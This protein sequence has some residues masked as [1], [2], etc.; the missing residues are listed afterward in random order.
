MQPLLSAVSDIDSL[1]PLRDI[2]G[3]FD[4]NAKKSL[5]QNFL[6]DLNITSKIVRHAGDLSGKTVFEI[7]P[8]PGGLTREILKSD[9]QKVIAVEFDPRAVAALQSLKDISNGRLSIQQ[10]DAMNVDLSSLSE[11]PR[12]IIANLP[13]NIASPLLVGWLRQ[14]YES[15]AYDS[16][17]LMF[18]K[19]V[20]QRICAY[21]GDKAYGR[22]A[23]ISQAVCK[24]QKIFD[25]PASAFVPPPKV[26]SSI[27]HFVPKT[28]SADAPRFENIEE[29]TRLAFGQ[30]RK[31]IRSSLKPYRDIID[32]LGIDPDL[33]A[34]DLDIEAY[35]NIAKK[36]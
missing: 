11:A 31:M 2:I 20:A 34:D 35:L 33:R 28:L 18:Q 12:C 19:E 9:A 29:V 27:V 13:Y 15:K 17:T 22:L 23:V 14:I 24:A 8:G 32:G 30:R 6:L 4:L 36:L 26:A 1:P 7:G 5:G 25:L 21:P 10:A 16:M 3:D